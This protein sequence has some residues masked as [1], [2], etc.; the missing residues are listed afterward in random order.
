MKKLYP[1]VTEPDSRRLDV[2]F[3]QPFRL[4]SVRLYLQKKSRTE[5]PM[6]NEET[7]SRIIRHH[8]SNPMYHHEY[9]KSPHGCIYNTSLLGADNALP[10]YLGLGSLSLQSR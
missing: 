4:G 3:V 6:A 9:P 1:D 2:L 7:Y 10:S 8:V 5:H